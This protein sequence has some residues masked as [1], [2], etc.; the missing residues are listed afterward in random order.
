[1]NILILGF[2][3]FL[4][5]TIIA[6]SVFFYSQKVLKI[7]DTVPPFELPDQDGKMQK[8]SD[9]R[10]QYVVLYFYLKDDTPGC[11]KQACNIR[12]NFNRLKQNK[13]EILGI[14]LD[15]EDS[16]K[17]FTDKYSLPFPLLSDI[18]GIVSKKYGVYKEKSF[19]G[20]K[21][22]G[23]KRTT[24]IINPEGKIYSIIKTV[25]VNN[26]SDQIINAIK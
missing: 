21:F 1:M 13:I 23:I 20:K 11:T 7:G 26:H 8:L 25:D 14:S 15:K 24:F 10:G 2:V 3:C 16:H 4:V 17:K 9:Y 5:V 22:F 12:D 18:E 6:V 19:F